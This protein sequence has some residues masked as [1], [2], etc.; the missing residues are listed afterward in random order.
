MRMR[1]YLTVVILAALVWSPVASEAADPRCTLQGEAGPCKAGLG[2]YGCD[3]GSGTCREILWGGCGTPVPFETKEE[4][5]QVCGAAKPLVI[6]ELKPYPDGRLPYAEISLEYPKDWE[7]PDFTVRVNGTEMPFRPWGGGFSPERQFATLLFFPGAARDIRVTVQASVGGKSYE[8]TSTLRW[9][10]WSMA[11]LLDGPGRIEAVMTARPLRFWA[12]PA[13][14][15][16][17]HWNGQ[18]LAPK[19]D[20]LSGKPVGLFSLEPEWQP[21]K[22]LLAI[23]TTGEDGKA[24]SADYSFVYLPDGTIGLGETLTIPYGAPGS[25]S[26]PFYSLE[27]DGTSLVA[28][29]NGEES[30]FGLDPEGWAI[31]RSA[32]VRTLKAERPGETRVKIFLQPHFLQ[33]SALERELR[34]TVVPGA[35]R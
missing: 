3:P 18:P 13:D 16:R 20:P 7:K 9:N 28:V 34:I 23:E 6:S 12:F 10:V 24:V 15:V 29:K 14:T 25:R 17:V 4:C 35:G 11:G 21:G 5:L 1:S 8:A 33:G 30:F 22:N 27:M 31:E 19:M 26:G 32:L 2:R